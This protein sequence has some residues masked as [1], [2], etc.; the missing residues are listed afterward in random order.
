MEALAS[1]ARRYDDAKTVRAA[2][3]TDNVLQ[4]G[5]SHETGYALWPKVEGWSEIQAF[6]R[7]VIDHA[8]SF[9]EDPQV[10]VVVSPRHPFTYAQPVMPGFTRWRIG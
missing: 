8:K 1:F 10:V 2:L 4:S 5:I 9:A 6:V 7:R 3:T